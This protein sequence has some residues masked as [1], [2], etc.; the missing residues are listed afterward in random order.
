M[1]KTKIQPSRT[2]ILG[3][4]LNN[5]AMAIQFLRVTQPDGIVDELAAIKERLENTVSLS[6]SVGKEKRINLPTNKVMRICFIAGLSLGNERKEDD[7]KGIALNK[8][9]TAIVPAFFTLHN[10]APLYSALL[11]MRY[12]NLN[13]DWSHIPTLSRIVA[14]EIFRGRDYLMKE[15]NLEQFLCA[16][17]SRV[18]LNKDIPVLNLHIGNYGDADME[19]TLDINSRAITNSQIII[20]GATGSGKTNLLN[21]LINQFRS[22]STES[23]YPVNFLLFDYKGEFSDI[24]NNRWLSYFDVDRTAIL[25]P[26]DR[27]LPF[28]PF[29]D[30]TGQTI[31]EIGLYASEMSSAL[32]SIDRISA[33]ATMSNRLREAIIEAYNSTNGAPIT[34]DMMLKNYQARM[35]DPEKDDTISSVLKQLV[36]A[37]IFESEDKA[38]LLNDSYI[39]KLDRYPRGGAIAKA[40]VYFLM[41]KLYNIYSD[42]PP[43]ETNDDVVQI[44]HFSI[45]DEA[46]YMLSFDNQPLRNLIAVG[47]NKGISIILATQNMAD[48]KSR[49]FDFYANAQ[50]PLIMRQQTID[51]KVIKDLFGVSGQELA[52]IRAAIG[53]LKKGE[54]IIKDQMAVTLGMGNKYKK[55]NVTHLI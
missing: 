39:I 32:S 55:I 25:D 46:H 29:K 20:A 11:K 6:R 35:K 43:Q 7:F 30:M 13:I 16:V 18:K 19:A 52:D 49:G 4:N 8:N 31:N 44:R 33:S 50:Y 27:P 24:Q 53:S 51:D 40:I 42:L 34:F 45:I 3:L 22:L 2:A 17:N 47:R 21:V 9:T 37:H 28:N 10:L 41:S 14:S 38:D 1:S 12:H 26:I 54:L 48:F 36:D 15:G 23:R 5:N